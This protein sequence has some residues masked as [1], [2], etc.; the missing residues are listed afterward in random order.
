V[1]ALDVLGLCCVMAILPHAPAAWRRFRS[2]L[3]CRMACKVCERTL[4]AP[5]LVLS[6][7]LAV[8]LQNM[9][10]AAGVG[11]AQAMVTE[12]PVLGP[13]G[14]GKVVIGVFDA[15]TFDRVVGP[16]LQAHAIGG[17]TKP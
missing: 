9:I 16:A 14:V 3:R 17:I 5:S 1:T 10:T 15:N 2:W 12:L 7:R 13:A 11:A 6:P 8:W 4:A